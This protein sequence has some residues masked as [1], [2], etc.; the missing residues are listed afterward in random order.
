MVKFERVVS[1]IC[2]RTDRHAQRHIVMTILP[3]VSSSAKSKV[4][5]E[6]SLQICEA[7]TI[8]SEFL[9]ESCGTKS[10]FGYHPTSL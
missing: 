9:L 3:R 2:V 10:A 5:T 8:Q 4:K 6:E 7:N 1:E